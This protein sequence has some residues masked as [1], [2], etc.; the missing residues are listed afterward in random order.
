MLQIIPKMQR[1]EEGSI[2]DGCVY[3]VKKLPDRSCFMGNLK[4]KDKKYREFGS[5][6]NF[7][8]P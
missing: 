6:R 8:A 7:F 2:R 4:G 3:A 5:K 1:E